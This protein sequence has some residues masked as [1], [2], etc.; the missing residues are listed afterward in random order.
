MRRCQ[1][2][3]V[4]EGT[5]NLPG[6]AGGVCRTYAVTLG[7]WVGWGVGEYIV[8][9]CEAGSWFGGHKY[10]IYDTL[11]SVFSN[12]IESVLSATSGLVFWFLVH[13][14]TCFFLF[15]VAANCPVRLR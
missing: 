5:P 12:R 6:V 14:G 10:N 13:V 8:E 1:C 7:V 15:S 9:I 2:V 11:G 4:A 3:R